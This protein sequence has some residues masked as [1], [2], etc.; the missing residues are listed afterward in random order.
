MILLPMTPNQLMCAIQVLMARENTTLTP[1]FE[2]AT[3]GHLKSPE[4]DCDYRY[5][6]SGGALILENIEKHGK[7]HLVPL[8][9]IRAALVKALGD[10]NCSS[11][12]LAPDTSVVTPEK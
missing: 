11:D 7:Y 10:L 12:G 8:G 2:G 4:V 6:P 9:A 5:D 3:Y 1:K